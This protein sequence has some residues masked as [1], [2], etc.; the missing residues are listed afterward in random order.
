MN[1]LRLSGHPLR[2]TWWATTW[3]AGRYLLAYQVTGWLLFSAA[4]TA[5]TMAA[6]LSVTLAG[7]PLL[8]AA[9][10]VVHGCAAAERSRLGRVL[11]EPVAHRYREPDQTPPGLIARAR[12]HWHDTATWRELAYLAGLFVP[13]LVLGCVVLAVWLTLA[14]G[15]TLPLWYWAPFNHFAHGVTV[16]GV[17]L[18]YFPNGPSGHGAW[19]VYVD[20][21]PKAL[22]TA[23]VCVLLLVPFTY[24]VVLAARTHAAVALTL[25]RPPED[26]LAA[27]KDMLRRPGPLS[28]LSSPLIRTNHGSGPTH[29]GP[30]HGWGQEPTDG[31]R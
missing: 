18:G 22:L 9:A 19:G 12:A 23:L 11:G 31:T 25:L 6:A 1:R 15:V 2:R 14:A 17:Q 4:L 3:R 28:P 30:A 20:T 5:A 8:V 7:I 21:L 26:P 13:L 29:E 10:G 27:A 16:H 24:V